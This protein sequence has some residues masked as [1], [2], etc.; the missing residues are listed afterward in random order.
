MVNKYLFFPSVWH[1]SILKCTNPCISVNFLVRQDWNLPSCAY[2]TTAE[3]QLRQIQHSFLLQDSH[4]LMMTPVSFHNVNVMM[5]L[6]H[7]QTHKFIMT[8]QIV[9]IFQTSSAFL[10][11]LLSCL[12]KSASWQVTANFLVTLKF[13]LLLYCYLEA[14]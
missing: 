8:S 11:L 2:I 10:S 3:I 14:F 6:C 4:F 1:S 13:I 5:S 7:H 9:A 12:L